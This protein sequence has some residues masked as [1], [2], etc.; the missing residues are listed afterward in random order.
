MRI[1]FVTP[2]PPSRIRVRGYGFLTYLQRQHEVTIITQC[3]SERERADVEILR[4]K[5]YKVVPVE[6]DKKQK[7]LRTGMALFSRVPL[8]VA[9]A[10]SERFAQ[11]IQQL[12][13]E[14]T[15]DVV[16]VEHL[17]GIASLQEISR[18]PPIVWDAVDC[19]SLLFEHTMKSGSSLPI[20]A[21]AAVDCKRTQHYEARLLSR[22]KHLVITSERD[23]EALLELYR[24]Y[25]QRGSEPEPNISVVPNGVD[26]EY[27]YPQQEKRRQGNLVFLG[28][29][30]YH[31]NIAAVL[32]LYQQIMP[33]I[34]QQRPKTTLTIVGS[35][36]PRSIRRLSHDARVE[37]TGYVDDIRPYMGRAEIMVSPMVYSVGIQN[38]VLE[39]MALGTPVVAAARVAAALHAQPEQDLLVAQSAQEFAEKTI[40]L[41]DN[42]ELRASLSQHGRQYVEQTHDW[43]AIADHLV[44]VYQQALAARTAK[45]HYVNPVG[46]R[47]AP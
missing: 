46:A 4:Q 36:P 5:G 28:K 38:K 22:F 47:S 21:M 11:A 8:Q 15:F 12:C 14:E 25:Q 32:Y 1:L 16:H 20:R 3:I 10:Q 26:L 35:N 37:I 13:A 44:D 19:I 43:A 7:I 42:T 41:M 45:A 27:F 33:L 6:E 17:R 31:A 29:M 34:W 9:Y 23:R 39:A 40:H 2:H 18:L 24:A 30:S